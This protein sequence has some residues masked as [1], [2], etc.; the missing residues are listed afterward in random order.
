MFLRNYWITGYYQQLPPSLTDLE[1]LVYLNKLNSLGTSSFF[2]PPF[3]PIFSTMSVAVFISCNEA[4]QISELKKFLKAHGC[5]AIE[6]TECHQENWW[7][8]FKKCLQFLGVCWKDDSI[9]ETEVNDIL[10]SVASLVIQLPP[11]EHDSVISRLC[12]QYLDFSSESVKKHKPKLFSLNL[13]FHGLLPDNHHKCTIYLT[14]V[15]CARKLG[16]MSQIITDPKKVASWL[17]TCGSSVEERQKIWRK[18]HEVHS[19]LNEKRRASEALVYLLSTYTEATAAQARQDAIKC[20]LSVIQ[21]PSLLAHDQLYAL[22]PIRFLEGEPV[23]DFLKIFVSGSLSA[24]KTFISKHPDFLTQNGL[25]EDACMQKLRLLSLMQLSEN[26][27]ELSYD[28]AARDL[29]LPLDK[30]E[31]FII[32]AVRQRA[33]ACKLDQVQRR[34]L[35]TGAFPRTFGRP[36]WVRLHDTLLQWHTGLD[37]VQKSIGAMI[38]AD[39]C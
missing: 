12:D 39:I 16:M 32:E 4:R 24:F 31:P 34:I 11:L 8:E 26:Q 21:D 10:T 1:A 20:I 6:S 28:A 37:N 36:Q 2:P 13:I 27:T 17:N 23:H 3:V 14:L 7:E 5:K 29:E 18:L 25:L 19:E 30:L 15:S 35:I 33:V 22:Y 38:Q 9:T